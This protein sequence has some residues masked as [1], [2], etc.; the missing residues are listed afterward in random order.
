MGVRSG[1]SYVAD[2]KSGDE[3]LVEQT[4]QADTHRVEPAPPVDVPTAPAAAT[5]PEPPAPAHP[6]RR[7]GASTE[8]QE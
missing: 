4:N 6:S 2:A 3:K 1:G 7:R 8:T 5:E